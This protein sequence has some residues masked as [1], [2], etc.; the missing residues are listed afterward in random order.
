MDVS[1]LKLL[2]IVGRIHFR[3]LYRCVG[4]HSC[5]ARLVILYVGF[6]VGVL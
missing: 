4:K 6:K 2:N 5:Y 3:V 1:G